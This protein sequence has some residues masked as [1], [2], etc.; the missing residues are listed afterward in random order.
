MGNERGS[1]NAKNGTST[2]ITNGSNDETD[3]ILVEIL[4]RE[5]N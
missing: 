3:E 1:I 4:R 5:R 2:T